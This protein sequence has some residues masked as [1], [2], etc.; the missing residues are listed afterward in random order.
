MAQPFDESNLI[1]PNISLSSIV[2]ERFKLRRTFV[3]VFEYYRHN[4]S[5]HNPER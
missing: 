1:S 4:I 2:I 5:R 3:T